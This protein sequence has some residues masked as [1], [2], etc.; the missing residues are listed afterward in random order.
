MGST[1]LLLSPS[2]IVSSRLICSA[3]TI[4]FPLLQ[5]LL[6]PC[7]GELMKSRLFE[8]DYRHDGQ[9]GLQMINGMVSH[10][11]YIEGSSVQSHGSM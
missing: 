9:G 4:I 5:P 6:E 11:R 2:I 1:T 3:I 10:G 7:Q 8:N